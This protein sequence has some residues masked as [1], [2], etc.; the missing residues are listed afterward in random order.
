MRGKFVSPVAGTILPGERFSLVKKVLKLIELSCKKSKR[1][2]LIH[3]AVDM[4][5][6]QILFLFGGLKKKL[7]RQ[8]GEF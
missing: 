2:C 1:V 6:L 7:N 4:L 3:L 5:I 8:S